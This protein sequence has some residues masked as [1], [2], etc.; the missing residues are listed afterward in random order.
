MTREPSRPRGRPRSIDHTAALDAAVETFWA[1]GYEG[2]SLTDLTKAMGLSRPSLYAAYGD[3][4]DLFARALDRYGETIGGAPMRVFEA[5]EDDADA[6][7]AFLAAS[8][9]GN[10]RPGGAQGCLIACCAA[11]AA[12]TDAGLRDR[13]GAMMTATRDRLAT[14]LGPVRAGLLLDMMYAQAVAARAGATRE[15]LLADLDVRVE[16]V[17][18]A[19]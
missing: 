2:A 12:G 10:T 17:M 11:T 9:E 15:A 8:A 4:A 3:K 1:R 7:R 18:G 16:A 6:V 14:R 13:L 5:A 19:R